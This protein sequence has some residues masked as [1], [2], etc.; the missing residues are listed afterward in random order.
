MAFWPSWLHEQ[1]TNPAHSNFWSSEMGG[2]AVHL[3]ELAIVMVFI[4]WGWGKIHSHLEC[5]VE[6]CT[7][8]GHPIHGTSHRACKTHHPHLDPKGYSLIEIHRRA[9]DGHK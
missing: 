1:W 7:R 4:R 2:V 3:L 6:G 9:R 8:L 5:H